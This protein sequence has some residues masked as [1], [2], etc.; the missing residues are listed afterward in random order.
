MHEKEESISLLALRY[1]TE[2][3]DVLFDNIFVCSR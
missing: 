3:E 1:I 2:N